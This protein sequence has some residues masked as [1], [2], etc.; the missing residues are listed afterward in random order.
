MR[1]SRPTTTSRGPQKFHARPVPRIGGVGIVAGDGRGA[2]SLAAALTR[3]SSARQLW[4]LLALRHARLRAGIAEDLTK[5]VAARWRLLATALSAAL[6]V[7]LLDAVIPRTDIPGLDLLIACAPFARRCSRSSCVTGV[8]NADQH[9]RRLQRPGVDVRDD[10]AAGDRLRRA[11][12]STTRSSRCWRWP[13]SA[14]C[15]ASS[16]GTSRPG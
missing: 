11:S 9:H 15:S 5:S 13:A 1:A 7:W 3:T 8:A 6:A 2:A 14:R 16:S 4:L 10:D 12:R